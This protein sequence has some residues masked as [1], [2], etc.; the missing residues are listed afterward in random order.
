MEI[1]LATLIGEDIVAYLSPEILDTGTIP[2][3]ADIREEAY[4]A[5]CSEHSGIGHRRKVGR[6]RSLGIPTSV[7]VSPPA[8]GRDILEWALGGRDSEQSGKVSW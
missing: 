2:L 4:P 5:S 3:K 8:G 7:W 1:T 6:F